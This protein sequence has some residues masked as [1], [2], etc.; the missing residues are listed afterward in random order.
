MLSGCFSSSKYKEFQ[1]NYTANLEFLVGEEYHDDL[2]KGTAITKEDEEVD[3]TD[4]M[5]VDAS[6]YNKDAVGTYKIYC[7][8]EKTKLSYEV[9]VVEEITNDLKINIRLQKVLDN[10][11]KRDEN[12]VFS[13]EADCS[14]YYNEDYALLEY[15]IFN[16]NNGEL[17][18]YLEYSVVAYEDIEDSTVAVQYWYEGT[19]EEGV[20]TMIAGGNRQSFNSSVEEF[21]MI[22]LQTE[23]PTSIYVLGIDDVSADVEDA[24]L[25]KYDDCY[26]IDCEDGMEIIYEDNLIVAVNDVWYTFPQSETTTI[27]AIPGLAE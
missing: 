11:F 7:E 5:T 16:D 17:S 8:F 23:L 27:P 10:T 9:K 15:M 12:D 25:T 21:N 6:A 4:Q 20:L 18:I 1:I 14:N 26:F 13:Y 22:L 24:T 3:V 2:L 19:E